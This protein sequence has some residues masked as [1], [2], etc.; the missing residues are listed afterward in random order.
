VDKAIWKAI[1]NCE[2]TFDGKYYYAVISTGIFCRPSCRSRIPRRENVRIFCSVN[3]AKLAGFRPCKRCRPDEHP[4]GPDSELVNRAKNIIHDRFHEQLTLTYLA[5]KLFVSP[6]HL[7]HV[8]KRLT[9]V[10]PA[11]YI[12]QTRLNK[13]M[14]ALKEERSRSITEIALGVGFSSLSH[15]STVFQRMTG[16]SPSQYREQSP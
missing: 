11:E 7:H 16:Q 14:A 15:F 6:Y 13:A 12:L 10:T 8:F 3:E 2:T 4:L 1:V 9:N 5:K